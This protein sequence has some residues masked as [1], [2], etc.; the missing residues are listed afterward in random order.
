MSLFG[1]NNNYWDAQITEN[2]VSAVCSTR[3]IDINHT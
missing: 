2:E 1:I 3:A